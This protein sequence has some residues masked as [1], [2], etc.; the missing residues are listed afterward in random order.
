MIDL[1]KAQAS[2]VAAI[3]ALPQDVR[4]PP[5]TTEQIERFEQ[6]FGEIPPE[7]RWFL[8]NCGGGVVGR[9]WL[10]GITKLPASQTKYQKEFGPPLGWSMERVFI[11]GWDGFGNP[12]GIH[13]PTGRVLLEDHNFGGITELAGSFIEYACSLVNGTGERTL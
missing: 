10:D 6:A 12:I 7:Y 5:A 1:A 2:I 13:K 4:E 11:I 8:L 9:E 3:S